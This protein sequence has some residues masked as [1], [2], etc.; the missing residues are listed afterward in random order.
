VP[1]HRIV[2]ILAAALTLA[3]ATAPRAETPLNLLA[4]VGM[5]GDVAANVAGDCATVSVLVGE[6]ADPHLY[7]PRASDVAR[8][9]SAE[10]ILH[11]GFGLE[12]Q[13]G[14]VLARL[15]QSRPVIAVGPAGVA[16]TELLAV[17]DMEG[18]DPHLWMDP[19]LWSG[20]VPVIAAAV[21]GARP[22]CAAA[23]AARAEAHAAEL[24]ALDRWMVDSVATIPDE[25]RILVTAH[26]AFGYFARATGL[27]VAAIQG[28][29]TEAEAS[30][31]D[32]GDVARQVAAERVPAVFVE[33]T[34][35]PRTV[36]AMIEA[37]AAQGHSVAIGG[38]LLSDAMGAA[39]T[40]EGTYIGMIHANT[41]AI[42]TALGGT[43][44][45]LPPA[46]SA[47][48]SRWGLSG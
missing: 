20:I 31:A 18:V 41:V 13:L 30:V 34:I 47:W 22:A 43:P 21:A 10:L 25:R 23:V 12:G 39:G 35:N 9:Q 24:A 6:G 11:V 26:D 27:R 45:P 1:R 28:L 40:P 3:A 38:T 17:D 44:L 48:A 37:V 19:G 14:S 46:L 5:V 15:E 8:L 33:S 4:T 36:Q 16:A 29:S 2:P 42:V 7:Q 32:I